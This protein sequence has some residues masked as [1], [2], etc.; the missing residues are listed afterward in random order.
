M[1][2]F[3]IQIYDSFSLLILTIL[4]HMHCGACISLSCVLCQIVETRSH[5]EE[6]EN[7]EE[8]GCFGCGDSHAVS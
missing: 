4:F 8:F 2:E 1:F 3:N 7:D 5:E 6:K